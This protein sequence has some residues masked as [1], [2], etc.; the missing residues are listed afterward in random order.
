MSRSHCFEICRATYQVA[1]EAGSPAVNII[2]L[3]GGTF[4]GET[5]DGKVLVESIDGCCKWAMK[6]DIARQWL[7]NEGIEIE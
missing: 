1:R 7:E 3:G 6:W 5:S 2:D 4:C